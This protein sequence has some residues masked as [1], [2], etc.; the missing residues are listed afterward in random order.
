MNFLPDIKLNK[1]VQQ[2]VA[3][4]GYCADVTISASVEKRNT[5]ASKALL[6]HSSLP[7]C[8]GCS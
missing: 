1:A 8:T 3:I 4:R 7:L 6:L 5:F 2:I